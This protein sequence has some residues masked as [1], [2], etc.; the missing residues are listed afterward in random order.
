MTLSADAIQD[1]GNL[2]DDKLDERDSRL[3]GRLE[4]RD[5]RLDELLGAHDRRLHQKLDDLDRRFHERLDAIGQDLVARFEAFG[6]A[7]PALAAW[8]QPPAAETASHD[9]VPP[10]PRSAEER[11]DQIER[12]LDHLEELLAQLRVGHGAVGAATAPSA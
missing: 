5:R 10:A 4:Q 12:R 6:A 11:I 3:N 7:Q 1:I 9:R 2:L 8:L